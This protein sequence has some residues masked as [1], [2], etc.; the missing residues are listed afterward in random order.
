[1]RRV[2]ITWSHAL[3]HRSV[4]ALLDH[5]QLTIVGDSQGAEAAQAAL[6]TLHP[7]TIIVEIV[8]AEATGG[9][10]VLR[11]LQTGSWNPRLI[12]VSL[13]DNT[14]QIYRRQ[15]Y[16]LEESQDLLHLVLGE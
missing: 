11:L 1:M 7:D 10:D 13:Q 9:I 3:F 2:F 4:C 5:P 12:C 8:G 16:T 15:P 14:V 6:E